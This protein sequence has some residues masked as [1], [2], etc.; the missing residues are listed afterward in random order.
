[1]SQCHR[2]RSSS[3]PCQANHLTLVRIKISAILLSND[4]QPSIVIHPPF[5]YLLSFDFDG[6]LHFPG[7]E[8]SVSRAFF[9]EL[10]RIRRDFQA[11]WG[12]NTGRSLEHLL[13]G[14]EEGRFPIDPDFIVARE[15][16]IYFRGDRGSWIADEAWNG[17]CEREI[18][19]LFLE[20]APLLREIRELVEEHTSAQ[21]I[22]MPGEPAGL[23]SRTEEEMDWILQEI[24]KRVPPNS[25]LGWQRSTIYLRFGDRDFQKGSALSRIAQQRHIPPARVFAIGDSH[26]DLEMLSPSTAAMA[27]CPA[28]AVA[29]IRD[30]VLHHGGYLCT[31]PHSHGV[32]E[33][34]AHFFP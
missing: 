16:E 8:P 26:N 34:M 7:D 10:L 33:A 17:R 19:R 1:M 20:C 23:I 13:E 27:A 11:A 29:D 14:M 15:R 3:H 12:I 21:W 28:N 25:A 4:M 18:S 24:I 22:E 32:A 6:T 9:S 31:L 30:H 5:Q 2:N